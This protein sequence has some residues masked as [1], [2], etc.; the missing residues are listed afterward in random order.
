M[1]QMLMDDDQGSMTTLDFLENA[2]KMGKNAKVAL[3]EV[4]KDGERCAASRYE[5]PEFA[6][7]A[8]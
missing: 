8:K 4:G 2:R 5:A 7:Q 1:A 6:N 3:I